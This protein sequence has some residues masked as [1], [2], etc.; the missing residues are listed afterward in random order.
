MWTACT[1][2]RKQ[3]KTLRL[4]A[5]TYADGGAVVPPLVDGNLK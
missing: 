2:F 3:M 4:I 1:N 5:Q